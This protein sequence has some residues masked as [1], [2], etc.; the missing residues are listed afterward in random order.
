MNIFEDIL[1]VN[2]SAGKKTLKSFRKSWLIIFTGLAYG[3]INIL[4]MIILSV[5]F[6][7]V[8]QILAGFILAIAS[9]M[10]VSNYLYL[11]FNIINYDRITMEDF[12]DGFKALLWDV[13]GVFFVFWI[14]SFLI[15]PLY[16]MAGENEM[17]LGRIITLLILF[18]LNPLPETIYQK[19]NPSS[20]ES[21]SY[22]FNFMKE[23]WINWLVPNAIFHYLIYLTTGRVLLDVFATPLN[24]GFS[25][26]FTL[27]GLGL[28]FLG[29]ILFSLTMIYRGHLF[30][31]LSTSTRNKRAYM[32][33]MYK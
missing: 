19:R 21:I 26:N 20:L 13:Y 9:A 5:F 18:A 30:K 24:F 33:N 25:F 22:A 17:L 7:G 4:L 16:R 29:Q 8:L 1:Y 28:Y 32:K 12:K 31:I 15:S 23:N 14:A 27:R 3:A 2:K 6:Q 10:L 11:L